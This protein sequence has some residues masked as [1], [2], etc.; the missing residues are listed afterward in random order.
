ME[1]PRPGPAR[2]GL[3]AALLHGLAVLDMFDRGRPTIGIGEMARH[4]GVHKSSASRLAATLA[5]AGYLEPDGEPG[6]YRLGRKLAELGELVV[7]DTELRRVALPPLKDLV[8]GLGETGHLAILEGREAVTVE[9]VDGWQTVRM[10]SWVG[11][12]SPAH[13]SSMGKA[14]LAGLDPAEIDARY[15]DRTLE[16]R[17]KR[18]ITDRRKLH[19][20]LDEVRRRGYAADDEELETYLCCVAAP[21]FDRRGAVV[22]SVSVSGPASRIHEATAPAI[23]DHVRRAA[24]RTSAQLGAPPDVPGWLPPPAEESPQDRRKSGSS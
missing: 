24:W 10:H 18:T 9:V 16:A 19:R 21:I 14:L 12:R 7:T 23:A 17:T 1:A 3:V 6:R 5:A 8:D 15:P 11:K 20:H 13:C 2:E 22:A 4:L